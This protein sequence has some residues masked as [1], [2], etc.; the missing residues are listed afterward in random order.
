M[1]EES[2]DV[3]IDLRGYESRIVQLK[4]I[5]RLP[6]ILFIPGVGTMTHENEAALKAGRI[7]DMTLIN[8][9]AVNGNG[10]VQCECG[11]GFVFSLPRHRVSEMVHGKPKSSS[12]ND[13]EEY[14]S[15]PTWQPY[16][17]THLHDELKAQYPFLDYSWKKVMTQVRRVL[18]RGQNTEIEESWVSRSLGLHAFIND[19]GGPPAADYKLTRAGFGFMAS[20]FVWEGR[21]EVVEVKPNAVM[22][23]TSG[24]IIKLTAHQMHRLSSRFTSMK[25]RARLQEKEFGWATF[26]D[27]MKDVLE[28]A[29]EG[30]TPEKYQMRFA[31]SERQ[32]FTK[33]TLRFTRLS[34]PGSKPP[35]AKRKSEVYAKQPW[36]AVVEIEE[37]AR[38]WPLVVLDLTPTQYLFFLQE[39]TLLMATTPGD[40]W[41]HL[42]TAQLRAQTI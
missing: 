11:C 18:I 22:D 26:R 36:N 27:F 34:V 2:T 37:M 20:S 5:R 1:T 30:F 31:D 24:K 13:I 7:G 17:C 38:T 10:D 15:K 23:A 6:Q 39:F 41:Q 35:G 16:W 42:R 8:P 9:S 4:N 28:L 29:P 19:I 12:V 21:G 33:E 25:S 14:L 32:G 40:V 3:K